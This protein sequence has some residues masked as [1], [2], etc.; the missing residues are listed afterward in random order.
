MDKIITGYQYGEENQFIGEYRFE[1]NLD[2]DEIYMPPKTTLVA[3]PEIPE[4]MRAIWDGA[5]WHV[6][7]CPNAKRTREMQELLAAAELKLA[8]EKAVLEELNQQPSGQDA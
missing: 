4:G 3:P 8:Q 6:C 7:E 5:S 1:N 2:R